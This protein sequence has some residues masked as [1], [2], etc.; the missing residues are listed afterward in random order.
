MLKYKLV[1]VKGHICIHLRL[2]DMFALLIGWPLY[3]LLNGP[4]SSY[5]CLHISAKS[6]T[7]NLEGMMLQQIA[8]EASTH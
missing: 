6:V 1:K 4:K 3:L 7:L 2:T 5:H 8:N